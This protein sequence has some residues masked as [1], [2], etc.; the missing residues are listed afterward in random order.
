MASKRRDWLACGV[1]LAALP[2][3]PALAEPRN[4]DIPSEEAAKS[5]PEFARQENIQIV[6]PVS[7]LHGIKTQAVSC[8]MELDEA[9][10]TLLVGTG[11]EVASNDGITI[12]LRRAAEA[13]PV[14]D[15]SE[16]AA[17]GIS[18]SE[19]IIVTGSRVISDPGNSPTPVT[20]VSTKQLR[21]TTPGNLADGLNKLPIFQGS[22]SIGRPG[23]GSQNYASN[24]LNLRNFGTQRTLVLLDGR[25]ALRAATVQC[26]WFGDIDTLPQDAAPRTASTR[27]HHPPNYGPDRGKSVW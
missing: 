25:V 23:D 16:A 17:I 13:P 4:I 7:Q 20:I 26:R 2:V 15:D 14:T 11:L 10:R 12:V 24:V 6:A 9:L 22:Q 21:N 1:A 8:R 18:P 19:S 3:G 5:I 27:R